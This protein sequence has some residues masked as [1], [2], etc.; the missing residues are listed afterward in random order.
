MSADEATTVA[1]ANSLYRE[2]SRH[3][4]AT[5]ASGRTQP[6]SETEIVQIRGLG[7]RLDMAEVA[8][9][10]VPLSRLLSLYAQST[11]RL[12]AETADFLGETDT[13]TPFIIGVAGSVAVG[14]STIARL[15]RE[16][17]SRWPGT[18]RVELVTTDGFL[19]PNAELERRGLMERKGFP[20][21]Y[22]RRALVSF[23]TEVKSGAPEV[24]A[25]F[26]SHMRYDIVPD[27]VVTVRRP[28]IVI[29]EGLNVLQPPPSPNDVAISELFDFSIFVDADA[30]HIAQWYVERFLALR[31][32]AFSNP[33]S[34]FNVFA[35][36]SDDEAVE[37]AMGYW[38][39][40]NLPNL[41]ENVLPTRHRA[42][43]VLQ[44]SA[45]HTVERVL[46]RKL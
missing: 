35:Q 43:L 4:W 9:V 13:T 36:L 2:I 7:D 20:E 18:P 11:K 23:L 34:F 45:G 16:L 29:V 33:N 14:K 25:P 38:N 15:L 1:P 26:Y 17:T 41:V 37:R 21:S 12:G 42:S 32:A 8:Q 39:D 44:K 28:D 10:Y 27:A 31:R 46:L 22:D 3:D 19:Y 40:I 24:R 5:L 6:L 30:E